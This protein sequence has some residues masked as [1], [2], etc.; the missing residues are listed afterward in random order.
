MIDFDIIENCELSDSDFPIVSDSLYGPGHQCGCGSLY[1]SYLQEELVAIYFHLTRSKS[2]KKINILREH[3]EEV[4]DFIKRNIKTYPEMMNYLKL[5]YRLI[6]QTRDLL[7]GKGEHDLTYMMIWV[8]YQ[9]TLYWLFSLFIDSFLILT[10]QE[11]ILLL[12]L[13]VIL[14]IFVNIFENKVLKQNN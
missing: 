14:N 9:N 5:F 1:D 13:G 2:S 11:I 4:L 7:H 10:N 12:V 3:L 8:W 6:G